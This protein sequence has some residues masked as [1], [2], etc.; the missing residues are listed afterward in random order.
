MKKIIRY[1]LLFLFSFL[2]PLSIY[3]KEDD[4]ITL[5]FFHGDGC[6]HCAE[7]EVFLDEL[8]TK[9]PDLTIN[10]LEVWYNDDNSELLNKVFNSFEITRTGVPA[11]VI[12]ETIIMG[13][14]ESIA[15]QIERAI[16]YYKDNE[17]IDAVELINQG[18]YKKEQKKESFEKEE[19]ELDE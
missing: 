8:Q 6:P 4:K 19:K 10:K 13:Y 18:K 2:L 11:N 15:K 1:T 16:D 12:G 3:A 7:E 9:Y 17:Y 14:S 5:Y